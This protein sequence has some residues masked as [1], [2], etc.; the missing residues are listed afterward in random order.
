MI[1][2]HIPLSRSDF[3]YVREGNNCVPT[4]LEPVPAGACPGIKVGE[5]YEGSSGWRKIPG[6]T[7]VGG[8]TKSEKVIKS[9]DKGESKSLL[10]F[11]KS[12]LAS[13]TNLSAYF[14]CM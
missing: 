8:K 10:L 12:Y 1:D 9:C 4:G 11:L 2:W 7:C 5:T 13:L 6:S 3:N 14:S